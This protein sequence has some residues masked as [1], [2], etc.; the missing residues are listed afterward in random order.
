VATL[1]FWAMEGE[2]SAMLVSFGTGVATGSAF[3]IQLDLAAQACPALTAGT[4]FALLM[5]LANLGTSL[6][7]MLGGRWYDAWSATWD[8]QTAFMLLVGV[9]AAFTAGCWLLVPFLRH[10]LPPS[11]NENEYDA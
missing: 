1:A 6:S 7:T 5:S 2:T 9:G 3:V 11:R 8:K 10:S 4:V